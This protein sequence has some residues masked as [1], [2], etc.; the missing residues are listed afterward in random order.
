[1]TKSEAYRRRRIGTCFHAFKT[2]QFERLQQQRDGQSS[3]T[4]VFIPSHHET[5]VETVTETATE[6]ADDEAKPT[7][8]GEVEA[9]KSQSSIAFLQY[10]TNNDVPTFDDLAKRLRAIRN[11]SGP[12]LLNQRLREAKQRIPRD[13]RGTPPRKTFKKPARQVHFAVAA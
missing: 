9:S 2:K 6:T 4:P 10:R 3:D 7:A 12:S 5:D 8:V 11:R 13:L 1:M